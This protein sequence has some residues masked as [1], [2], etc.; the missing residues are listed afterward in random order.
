MVGAG[1]TTG[2]RGPNHTQSGTLQTP[3][4]AGAHVARHMRFDRATRLTILRAFPRH[5]LGSPFPPDDS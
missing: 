3:A 2:A 4:F 1:P 5:P